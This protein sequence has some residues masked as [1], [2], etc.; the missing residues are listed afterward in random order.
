[1][2]QTSQGRSASGTGLPF[3]S[4]NRR[5]V[6]GIAA[7]LGASLISVAAMG[8][9][10]PASSSIA[11]PELQEIVVTGSMIKRVN[12]ETAEAV[13]VVKM[14]ALKDLGVTT[15]EQ[16]LALVTSNNATITTGSN[17]AT[18]NGGASVASL[19]GMGA[20]K[21]LVL[22]DG[23]RLAN[24]VTLG[25]GVDLNTIPFAAIDHI[26]VLREGAS[27]LYGSDAIAGVINFITKKDYNGG[28]VNVNYS[29]PQHPGGS[30]DDVD[31]TYG[32]GNLAS[33]GYNFMITGT[34]SQQR[35]LTA[36]QRPFSST[37]YNP[38]L[39]LANLN[40]P[41]APSP[42]S[43]QDGNPTA[44]GGP[45]LWQTG[46]PTC[47]GNPLL[48]ATAGSCQYKYSAAV[49]LIP[50]SSSESGLVSFTK[51]LP[52]NNTL[53]VQ[54]FYSRFDLDIWTGPQSY[55]FP[56]A[57]SSPYYP[58]AA[59]STCVGT[60][61]TA[62]PVLGGPI[63][64]GWTDPNN[65]RYFGNINT[66]QRALVT[67]AGENG[68]W[69]YSTS[70]DWSQ[71]K[72]VQQVRGGEANYA[73]IAPGGTLSNLINPF[74]PQSAGGQA[75]INSAYTQGNLEVGTLSLYSLNGHAS[76]PLGDLFN[77]GH[78]AQFAVGFDYRDEQ[79]SDIPTQLATTLYT[80][81]YFPPTTVVGSRVSE[82]AFFELNV[83]VTSK[84]EFT[85]SDRQD[86]YSDF[87]TTNNAKVSFAY[88]PF[89]ILKIRGAASTGFRAP[90]LV[91]EY[92]P[93]TFGAV[94][95]NMVGPGCASG[96]YTTVFSATNCI[97][98]GLSI[99]GGNA[100][101]QPE[102]SQ[103][104]DLGFVVEPITNLDVTV[105]YYR[106]NLRSRIATVPAS[107]IYANPT[108][109]ANLY[110]LNSAG[111]L[112]PAPLS[113]VQCPTPQASTCGYVIQTYNNTGAE[114][115]DGFDL[116]AN[117]LIDSDFGKFR[118]GLEGTFVTDFKLQQYQ[119]GPELNLVGQFNG[120]QQPVIRW[121]H[122]L[123]LDWTYQDFGAGLSN[124]FTEHY[125]DYAPDA[126][127]NLL[128]VGNYSIWN[129]YASWK[130]IPPLKLLVGINN[131][132]DTNPPFSNQEQNWQAGF[133][134]IFSNPL[135]RTFYGRVTYKF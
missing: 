39:G 101:L 133:N 118:V 60:C 100:A 20:T 8:Q 44:N 18:F 134:P 67:F 12:A 17:V 31:V 93:N 104:F 73:I 78:P 25:S 5:A 16:A 113:N 11:T 82:A 128:T 53:S 94:F 98:Q 127:G 30:S 38:A 129:G 87:G 54:Y 9:Q 22:L 51:A 126:A 29:K 95:G 103:N 85:V 13:T 32:I 91:E 114:T 131:L 15:V 63:T 28:E 56:M 52:G 102:T 122:L 36:L 1:M 6:H 50:K 130:P 48:V 26:E 135:G 90:S 86:R 116:S 61:N 47:A 110:V 64:A 108:A 62:T 107:A 37:G 105:D 77:A 75:L 117:Y 19:R 23:Q 40:G 65:N 72:G 46:Y 70:F 34:Y 89:S 115:T 84:A 83:P 111:T 121:Q 92:S 132:F 59:N 14:D 33:D 99:T 120:G 3:G 125:T 27:S 81:T 35:E 76:H 57:P 97:S 112:T 7:G 79:I 119:G 68:G 69:D 42:G 80:A 21:T 2:M 123:T 106:I 10:A 4:R 74:G 41:Y 45:S 66:E 96:H 58:T 49:D 43:Y 88:Q 55:S 109:F 124:H 24:N 71:N